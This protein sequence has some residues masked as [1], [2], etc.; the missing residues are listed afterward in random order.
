[1]VAAQLAGPAAT[2]HPTLRR[3]VASVR[4][5]DFALVRDQLDSCLDLIAVAVRTPG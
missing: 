3:D 1:V 2:W 4:A 5:S